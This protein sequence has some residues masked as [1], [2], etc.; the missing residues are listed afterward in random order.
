M[1]HGWSEYG[2]GGMI[3]PY[4]MTVFPLLQVVVLRLLWPD[5]TH[6]GP[7]N[8]SLFKLLLT[9]VDAS[10]ANVG[11][12]ALQIEIILISRSQHSHVLLCIP[13]ITAEH[14]SGSLPPATGPH[15]CRYPPACPRQHV[16]GACFRRIELEIRAVVPE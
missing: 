15:H 10:I 7:C 6:R 2:K 14:S 11:R 3:V 8:I 5:D 16:G 4:A 1:D 12:A 13:I 9:A